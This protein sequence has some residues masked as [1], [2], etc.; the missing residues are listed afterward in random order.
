MH[1]SAWLSGFLFFSTLK[2]YELLP[3]KISPTQAPYKILD[4]GSFD[5]NGNTKTAIERSGFENY[6]YTGIDKAKGPNVNLVYDEW[7]FR[8]LS[9]LDFFDIMTTSS[10]FEHDDFFWLTFLDIVSSL[11]PGGFLFVNVPSTGETHRYPVDSWRFYSDSAF[12][13]AK[14]ARKFGHEI[15]VVHTL[16]LPQ[17]DINHGYADTV[18]IFWK[19]SLSD[20]PEVTRRALERLE[21]CFLFFKVDLLRILNALVALNS[22]SVSVV[23]DKEDEALAIASG[24][25]GGDPPFLVTATSTS[26]LESA[27]LPM[28]CND[29]QLQLAET[30]QEGGF[31][32]RFDAV[33]G[34]FV[35]R[36]TVNLS[37][38]RF[39]VNLQVPYDLDRG[40]ISSLAF[41]FVST[42]EILPHLQ[43]VENLIYQ[44]LLTAPH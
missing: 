37:R 22:S 14:W 18:M 35:K 38:C 3:P 31:P 32:A 39:K 30:Y 40:D 21:S 24:T 10:C 25:R 11:R 1:P 36:I 8:G 42:F 23:L 41:E 7:P 9:E 43:L 44:G 27:N 34:K 33:I 15:F 13:L 2:F 12:S 26:F 29:K 19:A 28:N 6:N 17:H 20:S 4:I 16:T 5:V